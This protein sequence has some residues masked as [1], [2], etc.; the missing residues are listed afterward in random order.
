MEDSELIKQCLELTSKAMS[1][2]EKSTEESHETTRSVLFTYGAVIIS[3]VICVFLYSLY[4]TYMTYSYDYQYTNVNY[5][6]NINKG[7]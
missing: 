6:E 2:A 3:I 7:E 1:M 5:N 4:S